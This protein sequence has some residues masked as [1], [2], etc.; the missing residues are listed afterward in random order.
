MYAK[1]V[2]MT[3]AILLS[4]QVLAQSTASER[5]QE[6]LKYMK[7]NF[8]A[9]YHGEYYFVRRD[10]PSVDKKNESIQDIKIM[11][12]PTIIYKPTK[13][14]QALATAEFKYSDVDGLDTSFPNTFFRSLF[15]LTRK[16]ILTEKENG[17]QLDA[18]IGRRQFN[19]GIEA[20]GSYGN[21]RVFSTISKTFNKHKGSVFVQYLHN[22]YKHPRPTTWKHGLELIPTINLQLT[23]KLTW[24]IN[25]DIVINLPLHDNTARDVSISHE[26]NVGYVNY[27]WNDKI[28]TYYQ[29]KYYHDENF[30]KDPETEKD[31]F[32]HYLGMSYA[33]TPKATLTAE[34]G[35]EI[36]RSKDGQDVLTKKVKYPE[37][38]LYFDVS[39]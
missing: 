21:N 20:L 25:D 12:N 4:G 24:L 34:V 15:T 18:G 1:I 26:M 36:F 33:F 22:D 30:T 7:E 11:H 10:A 16:N 38:A 29:V 27:Q 8:S 31:W 14:W 2:L 17:I 39:I 3:A 13:N 37:F 9:S 32:E 28:G 6:V 5:T 35:S 23:E 19:T